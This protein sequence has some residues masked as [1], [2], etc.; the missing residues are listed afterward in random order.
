MKEVT[1]AHCLAIFRHDPLEPRMRKYRAELLEIDVEHHVQRVRSRDQMNE[2]GREIEHIFE[3]MIRNA[4]PGADINVAMV[5]RVDVF[6]KLG[7]VL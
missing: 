4:G 3:P 1:R 7:M 6:I 2:I 5:N